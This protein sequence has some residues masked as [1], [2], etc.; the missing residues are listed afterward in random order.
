M[1][2][3]VAVVTDS[4]AG[5]TAEL[6]RQHHIL[7]VPLRV[8]AGGLVLDDDPAGLPEALAG[9]LRAGRRLSTT[10]PAPA[11]FAAAYAAAAGAGAAAIVSVHLS[12]HLSGT[13]S[14]ASLAAAGAAVPVRI[15]DSRSIGMGLGLAV[16][17]AARAA[18][19][20]RSAGDVAAITAGRCAQLGSFFALDSSADLRAGGRLGPAGGSHGGALTARPLLYIRDGRIMP[21]ERVRT[22]SAAAARLAELTA[23]FAAGRRVD[24]AVQHLGHAGHAAA[25]ASRLALAVPGLRD[26]YLAE[27]GAAIRAHTGPGMLG[28]AVAP[29]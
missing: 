11:A 6:V 18:S 25:L 19:A 27:A 9:Q 22:L 24:L 17:A 15:V 23:D 21:L 16:L 10:R 28:V 14:S 1:P 26:S 3:H 29:F 7:V 5:L 20:G 8:Q 4:A 2:G 13:V 12:G